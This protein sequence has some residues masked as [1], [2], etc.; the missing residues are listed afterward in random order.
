[1]P[2][3]LKIN[4]YLLIGLALIAG[5]IWAWSTCRADGFQTLGV[6]NVVYLFLGLQNLRADTVEGL[7]LHMVAPEVDMNH[8]GEVPDRMQRAIDQIRKEP[9]QI[10]SA[11]VLLHSR[12]LNM[13]VT[14]LVCI[15]TLQAAV[16]GRVLLQQCHLHRVSTVYCTPSSQ[17]YR[18]TNT[19]AE[20]EVYEFMDCTTIME[21]TGSHPAFRGAQGER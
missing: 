20:D 8:A 13:V 7:V 21:S 15:S 2:L 16:G 18:L 9:D 5:S 14:V 3:A 10:A 4:I 11:M 19:G 1:M 17:R 12:G 6:F